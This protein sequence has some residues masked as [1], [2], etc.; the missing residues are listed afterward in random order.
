MS[1]QD[2]LAQHIKYLIQGKYNLVLEID[3]ATRDNKPNNVTL[4]LFDKFNL[5]K[6]QKCPATKNIN[7]DK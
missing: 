7:P 1:I 3:P 5:P 2:I 4:P 6:N